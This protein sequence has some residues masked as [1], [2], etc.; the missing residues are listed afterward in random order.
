[1]NLINQYGVTDWNSRPHAAPAPAVEQ[2]QITSSGSGYH[3]DMNYSMESTV[4]PEGREYS[5]PYDSYD[6]PRPTAYTFDFSN[7]YLNSDLIHGCTVMHSPFESPLGCVMSLSSG[8][9]SLRSYNNS[10]Q[11]MHIPME[12]SPHQLP[13]R[14]WSEDIDTAPS[15]DSDE[16]EPSYLVSEYSNHSN[17]LSLAPSL[18]RVS[19]D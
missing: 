18:R 3:S 4:G 11:E 6:G 8:M 12:A 2:H 15:V 14:S 16:T 9:L 10:R 1:M 5:P 13:G 19:K 17:L 7:P